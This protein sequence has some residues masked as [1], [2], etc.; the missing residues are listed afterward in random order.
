M[1]AKKKVIVVRPKLPVSGLQESCLSLLYL[2]TALKKAGYNAVLIDGEHEDAA[3]ELKNH[4][5]DAFCPGIT[6]MAVLKPLTWL[7]MK[8]GYFGLPLEKKIFCAAQ[9]LFWG[10][11]GRSLKA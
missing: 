10:S 2:G 4:A 7:R 5:K 3:S 11:K 1:L 8:T 6:A 9:R